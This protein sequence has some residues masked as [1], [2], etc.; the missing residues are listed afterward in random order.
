MKTIIIRCVITALLMYEVYCETG[1]WT[2]IALTV[3]YATKEAELYMVKKLKAT[4]HTP[5]H[6]W[7]TKHVPLKYR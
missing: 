1:I 3:V 4:S 7:Y 5:M 6:D 2:A